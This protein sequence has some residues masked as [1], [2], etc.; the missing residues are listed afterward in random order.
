MSQ[1]VTVTASQGN[2]GNVNGA[3]AYAALRG[4]WLAR[5]YTE[6]AGAITCG[7]SR[8]YRCA[9]AST[10]IVPS[11]QSAYPDKLTN[12]M[13]LAT[14]MVQ[15]S[16][17]VLR[18]MMPGLFEPQGGDAIGNIYDEIVGQGTYTGTTFMMIPTRI[19]TTIGRALIQ[20]TGTW[21]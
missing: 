2:G 16:A 3:S 6:I 21:Y 11:D 9:N 12:S 5:S 18:G 10:V 8:N 1:N 15:E 20:I 19:D 7:K 13:R 17:V 4:H 14:I